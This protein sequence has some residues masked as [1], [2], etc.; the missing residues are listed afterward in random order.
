M[1]LFQMFRFVLRWGG[2]QEIWK[3]TNEKMRSRYNVLCVLLA[4]YNINNI[5][6]PSVAVVQLLLF[7][8]KNN[9]FWILRAFSSGSLSQLEKK[10]QPLVLT[11]LRIWS[12]MHL[13]G[14][15]QEPSLSPS[16]KFEHKHF[17]QVRQGC[18]YSRNYTSPSSPPPSPRN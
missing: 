13:A 3:N 12:E 9:L 7:K 16:S 1:L 17:Y 11:Y 2:H 8:S 4:Q 5:W 14:A 10:Y 6:Q 15:P 18:T